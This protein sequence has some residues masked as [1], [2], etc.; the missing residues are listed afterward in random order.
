MVCVFGVFDDFMCQEPVCERISTGEATPAICWV[1]K[2]W[3]K[4]RGLEVVHVPACAMQA[5]VLAAVGWKVGHV[6][7]QQVSLCC[8]QDLHHL[9]S[10]LI[11]AMPVRML[12]AVGRKAGHVPVQQV[13]LCCSQ[14]L[15]HRFC[16]LKCAADAACYV[17]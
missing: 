4:Q 13:S 16:E 3:T 15:Q 2:V 12:A 7:L 8:S 17:L 6:F 11:C 1:Q 5:W 10:E 9:F 14:R